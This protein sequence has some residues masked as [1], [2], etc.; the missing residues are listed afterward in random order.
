MNDKQDESSHERP[1]VVGVGASA[2]GLDALM[3]MLSSLPNDPP[4]AFV[5]IQHLDPTHDSALTEILQ[6]KTSLHVQEVTEDT[7][8]EDGY[9]YVIPP[10]K[11][12]LIDKCVLKL[13]QPTE[14]RGARMS[15]DY[16]FRSLAEDLCEYAVG[17]VLSGTGTD[18]T[19]GLKEIKMCGGLTV[20]QD[21]HD[22]EHI[23]MPQSAINALQVDFTLTAEQI[24]HRL[25]SYVQHAREHSL[26]S[27]QESIQHRDQLEAIITHLKENSGTDFRR[28]RRNTMT[29]RVRRRMGLKQLTS[30]EDYLHLLKDDKKEA[31]SLKSDLLI[32]VT[33]FFRNPDAWDS[34]Q[35]TL[36]GPMIKASEDSRPIRIWCAGC[37]SGEEVYSLAMLCHENADTAPK[38]PSFQIFATDISTEALSTAR[39]G[40]YPESVVADLTST[41]LQHFFHKEGNHYQV[42]RRLRETIVF[43]EQNVLSHPPFSQ[44]D[45]IVCRNLL[46]YLDR[47]AQR[48]VLDVF[49]FALKEGGGLFLGSSESTGDASRHFTAIDKRWRLFK[50]TATAAMPPIERDNDPPPSMTETRP[51]RRETDQRRG[52]LATLVQRQM[53]REAKM[54]VAVV[55]VDDRATYLQ[56]Q[57]DQYLQTGVGE[58]GGPPPLILDMV[59]EG[60]RSKVRPL[61]RRVRDSF[62]THTVDGRVRRDG[63]Y[64]PV[65]LVARPLRGQDGAVLLSFMPADISGSSTPTDVPA[66][67]QSKPNSAQLAAKF[68]VEADDK[69][70]LIES[71]RFENSELSHELDTTRQQL[72]TTIEDLETANEELQAANEESMAVNEELQAGNEELETSKE[73]LQSLNEELVTLNNQLEIKLHQLQDTT[74]DLNNLLLS[75]HLPTVFIDT[76]F[77]IRRFTPSATDLFHLIPSDNGRPLLDVRADFNTDELFQLAREVLESLQPRQ[78]DVAT[79]DAKSFLGRLQPYRTEDNHIRGVVMTFSDVT[80]LKR[81]K[82]IAQTR[83]AELETIYEATP[84]GLSFIAKD[85]TY[86]SINRRLAEVNGVSVEDTIGKTL[87]DVLPEPLVEGVEQCYEQVFAT[88]KPID[89]LEVIGQ[90]HADEK[91]HKYRVSYHPVFDKHADDAEVIGVNSVVEDVTDLRRMQLELS[92]SEERLRQIAEVSDYVFWITQIDPE[93]VLYVSPAYEKL[94]GRK[95]KDL[96]EDAR[97]WSEAI[98]VDDR[99]R[100]S[101]AFERF[102]SEPDVGPFEVEYRIVREGETRWIADKA[103]AIRESDGSINRVA[104]VARDITDT[105]TAFQRLEISEGRARLAINLAKIGVIEVDYKTNQAV[106]DDIAAKTF[107]LPSGEAVS[108]NEIHDRFH[109][110]ERE[111]LVAEI[112]RFI[113]DPDERVSSFEH[114]VLLPDGEVR[115]VR[116][117]KRV[118][119]RTVKGKQVARNTVVAVLDFTD[120]HKQR[121][122]LAQARDEAEAANRSRG[123][124]L[125]NMSHEIRTPMAAILGHA[126]ILNDHLKD[127]DNLSVVDTI[128]RNGR[129]LLYIINDIL[130]LSKIDAGKMEVA[131][132]PV[133]PDAIV[134]EVRSLMDVRAAEKRL[135]LKIEFDG[136]VPEMIDTDPVRLRQVLLNLVGNAIKFTDDGEVR[137]VIRYDQ[138][139][140]TMHFD[141]IDT[142]LGIAEDKLDSL[143]EPFTQADATTTRSAGGT[144]LG[145]TICRR[146]AYSLGGEITADSQPG[147]GSRF[148]L[149][150]NVQNETQLIEPNLNRETPLDA[151]S[152]DPQIS[153][154]VLIVDDRRDIR[155][156]AQHFVEK[157]G[158]TVHTATNGREAVDFVTAED[159][160]EVDIIVMDM[161]MPVM[162]GYEAVAELRQFGCKLPIIALTANAM[163]EDRDECLAAGCTDYTT[164]P[165]DSKVMIGMIDRLVREG[166]NSSDFN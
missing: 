34:L 35:K 54:G 157:A 81:S 33:K 107:G 71:L 148:S 124:F 138:S 160:P 162:D 146:L 91:L 76:H 23:G 136:P 125:A 128:R 55:N 90:T 38:R 112:D 163:K 100:V 137:F 131:S 15:I 5:I 44:L 66:P 25:V 21:P 43:A 145:L 2:G 111:G 60:L 121:E 105:T 18:G 7:E 161:Q 46:I 95:A 75:T 74:D 40:L 77:R 84:I 14:E 139:D 147:E 6:R 22:A 143:F 134:G 10:G 159:A 144:G 29:R 4:M 50:R 165:V 118:Y 3:R 92:T 80:D 73:E 11:Y 1:V 20:A 109:P 49:Q 130:D 78:C 31:A 135:P 52:N 104:G 115:W 102:I 101:R 140:Q 132:R 56:G 108:R 153:C 42:S 155:Y 36:L 127:P 57:I 122:R 16:F 53:I 37:A 154:S 47:P 150:L 17:V 59:R 166:S 68:D 99:E 8:I 120:Q 69:D 96:L 85:R 26:L 79:T 156:L 106:L 97:H 45:L 113:Q 64:Y 87:R 9:V 110:E 126:D 27:A 28:Y 141:V 62:D 83:L 58:L 32:G 65:R 63:K 30:M 82:Q 151:A 98:H 67:P 103:N 41:R 123:E 117:S 39:E 142:G 129:H 12:L 89:D 88:G 164:K 86:R 93:R 13:T 51:T 133:R 152:D 119:Y 114:R 70:A 72:S 158:G 149:V 61:L 48:R 24:G 19:A 94:W 116:A